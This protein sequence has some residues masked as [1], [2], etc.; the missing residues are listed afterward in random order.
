M[1][2]HKKSETGLLFQV[3]TKVSVQSVVSM[4][5]TNTLKK[6]RVSQNELVPTWRKW[7]FMCDFTLL[8]FTCLQVSP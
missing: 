6:H 4:L 8:N 2:K 7:W 1:Q 3:G 5:M